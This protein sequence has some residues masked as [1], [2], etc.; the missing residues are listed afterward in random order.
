MHPTSAHGHHRDPPQKLTAVAAVV[1][2]I[3]MLKNKPRQRSQHTQIG[4]LFSLGL[5][6]TM[7]IWALLVKMVQ[8]PKMVH[9]RI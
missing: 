8:Q 9:N 3:P 4:V 6:T 5:H 7:A 1:P 2:L